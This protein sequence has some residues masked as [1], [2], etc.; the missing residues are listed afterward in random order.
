MSGRF[1]ELKE[2]KAVERKADSS[3]SALNGLA[4]CHQGRWQR[5]AGDY[6]TPCWLMLNDMRSYESS[7]QARSTP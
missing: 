2:W 4:C 3:G 6:K 7:D 1:C 5:H